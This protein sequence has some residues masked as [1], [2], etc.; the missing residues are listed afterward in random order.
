MRYKCISVREFE[1]WL[2]PNRIYEGDI[3]VTP[4]A[5][6]GWIEIKHADDNYPC[7]APRI[8]L[9]VITI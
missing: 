7:F 3:A 5:F 6:A 9:L 8:N 1:T 4:I 2:T